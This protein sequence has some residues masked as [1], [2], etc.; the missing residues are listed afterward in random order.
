LGFDDDGIINESPIIN[1]GKFHLIAKGDTILSSTNINITII[2][3][4]LYQIFLEDL[5][6]STSTEVK[7]NS[8]TREIVE[9]DINGDGNIDI[10]DI[11]NYNP[12]TDRESLTLEYRS[13][14]DKMI[15]NILQ[16]KSFDFVEDL[17]EYP[18]TEVAIQEAL[19]NENYDYVISQL[20]S[21]REDYEDLSDD[22]VNINIAGAYVGKSGYT[23]FDITTAISNSEN[24]LNEFVFETTKDNDALL[25]PI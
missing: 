5:N 21:N 4:I 18:E 17:N 13:N 23:V 11:L 20:T 8:I 24:G 12:V 2:S 22:D 15:N 14:L 9:K 16:G 7:L 25:L 19:D 6:N 1:K 3:E 10:L